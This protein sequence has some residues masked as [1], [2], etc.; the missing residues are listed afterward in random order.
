MA[1]TDEMTEQVEQ[2]EQAEAKPARKRRAKAEQPKATVI[3][4]FRGIEEGGRLFEV[5][6]PFEGTPE[7]IERLAAKGLVRKA[8]R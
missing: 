4:R 3:H 2:G 6:E 7:R 1:T 8:S 5:G